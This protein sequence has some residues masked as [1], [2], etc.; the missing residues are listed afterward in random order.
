VGKLVFETIRRDYAAVP[1]FGENHLL[2]ALAR[3]RAEQLGFPLFSPGRADHLSDSPFMD[4]A[5]A[6]EALALYNPGLPPIPQGARFIVGG[7]QPALLTGPLYTFLKAVSAII[8]SHELSRKSDVPIFPLFWVASE[9][10][11]ILE[12]NRVT[13]NGKRFV[14]EYGGE[15]A[16]GKVPQVAD[17]SLEAAREPLL[18]FLRGSLPKTEFTDMVLNAVAS[19]DYSNYATAFSSLMRE[20]FSEWELRLVDPIALRPLAA[21]VLASLVERWP[22]VC[23]ALERGAEVLRSAGFSP[24]LR[25]PGVF[26]ITAEGRVPIEFGGEKA[27]V[28]G[29][30]LSL[31][32]LAE[33]IRRRPEAFSP[34]AALRPVLQDAVLPVA[35]TVAGPA[36]L[37]YLWQVGPIFDLVEVKRSLLFPRISAT[38]VENRIRRAAEKFGIWPD[39]IFSVRDRLREYAPEGG[40]DS[41]VAA[42]SEK[43]EALLAELRR[44]V[45]AGGPNWL[46]RSAKAIES[47]VGEIVRRLR[48]YNLEQAGLGRKRLERIAEAILPDGKLQERV[49][50]PLQF[51]NLY[52][53]DFTRRAVEALD[54]LCLCHHIVAISA[55]SE[56]E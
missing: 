32:E 40:S 34:N 6:R 22:E 45:D 21:P 35:A 27:R 15:I 48:E 28:G 42:I 7:Q 26:E 2:T 38:F 46:G 5:A 4:I 55:V 9:D 30:D 33:Q 19:A 37:A 16:R 3:G 29:R 49:A 12:V 39:G 41:A 53:P 31:A 11:D 10:H 51:I 25:A 50:N 47:Q 56:G 52:G 14:Q 18:E 36:E 43:G 20:I 13:V 1:Q 23:S 24:P 17:I 54:P 44:L 8:L